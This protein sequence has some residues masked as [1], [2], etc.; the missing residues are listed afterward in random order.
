MKTP[1]TNPGPTPDDR[2]RPPG[3][4]PAL[5]VA[6]E[7]AR[8]L[9]DAALL[10]FRALLYMRHHEAMRDELRRAINWYQRQVPTRIDPVLSPDYV[11]N[12]LTRQHGEF[13]G[14]LDCAPGRRRSVS[15]HQNLVDHALKAPLQ[16]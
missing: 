10:P 16:P 8:A 15:S 7:I 14:V 1:E 4:P 3:P 13:G 11:C 12:N 9:G 2:R 6:I 5:A